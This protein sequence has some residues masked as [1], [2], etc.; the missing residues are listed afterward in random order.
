[1]ATNQVQFQ[2]GLSI[3]EFLQRYGSEDKCEAAIVASRWP[4]GFRCP[5]CGYAG[6]T[7]FVRARRVIGSAPAATI[8]VV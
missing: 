8:S 2:R 5:Q 6:H 3:A 4:D 7:Q 1:M